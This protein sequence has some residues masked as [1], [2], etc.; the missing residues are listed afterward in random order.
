MR[1]GGSSGRSR[2]GGAPSSRSCWR[3]SRSIRGR[4][5]V[6]C[7]S[8]ARGGSA[9]ALRAALSSSDALA[10]ARVR[11]RASSRVL[12][13]QCGALDAAAR[14]AAE[15][16]LRARAA[17]DGSRGRL[18]VSARRLAVAR[19]RAGGVPARGGRR[20]PRV[21]AGRRASARRRRAVRRLA[22][23]APAARALPGEVRARAAA[24]PL[25]AGRVQARLGALRPDPVA[26]R[27]VRAGGDGASRRHARGDRRVGASA[28][29]RP[30]PFVLLAQ[31]SLWDDTRAPA[32]QHTAWAYCHVPNGSTVEH[33]R[34]DRGAGRAVRARLP[35]P[36]PRPQR[37]RP[38]GARV[39]QPQPRRR[40]PERRPDGP[41]PALARP[42]AA[43]NPYRTP[44]EG[45]YLC[46]A[47]TPPGGGVHGMCGFAAAKVALDDLSRKPD[48]S[49][50][51]ECPRSRDVTAY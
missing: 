50:T 42:V 23:G 26:R 2:R 33:D 4:R 10:A 9:R 47:S 31:P 17:D 11:D 24:V 13:R 14:A 27:A 8:S 41:P 48:G 38:G 49:V 21:V 29:A 6:S 43:R 51:R 7:A 39:P 37:T 12:R 15:R 44:R 1:T 46:S 20:D 3:R 34:R 18:A 36:H 30:R 45:V 25:R 32:G 28:A 19:R 22:A 35:R 16:G 40:R 5:C